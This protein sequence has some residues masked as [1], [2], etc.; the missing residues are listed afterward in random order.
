MI[1]ETLPYGRR[2]HFLYAL[3]EKDANHV[4]YG[5]GYRSHNGLQVKHVEIGRVHLLEMD[6]ELSRLESRAYLDIGAANASNFLV[7]QFVGDDKKGEFIALLERV[8]K[9]ACDPRK[10][11]RIVRIDDNGRAVFLKYNL[12]RDAIEIGL[13]RVTQGVSQL[14]ST[15][16]FLDRA[17]ALELAAQLFVGSIHFAPYP[18][19]RNWGDHTNTIP[20]EACTEVAKALVGMA[21]AI[22]SE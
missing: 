5:V 14:A 18:V 15:A 8:W 1:Y 16:G 20:A 13:E 10:L 12:R 17:G 7:P 3:H 11:R 2:F 6:R 4:L 9:Q 19:P 22:W 21:D